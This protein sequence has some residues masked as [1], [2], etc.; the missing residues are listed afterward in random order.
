MPHKYLHHESVAGRFHSIVEIGESGQ[1]RPILHEIDAV[2]AL[3]RVAAHPRNSGRDR[4]INQNL[5]TTNGDFH[6]AIPHVRI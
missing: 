6:D 2:L 3:S 1:G 5:A 4:A